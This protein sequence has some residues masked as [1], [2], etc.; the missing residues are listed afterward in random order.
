MYEWTDV[1][2]IVN[3]DGGTVEDNDR[4]THGFCIADGL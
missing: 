1:V 2:L 4:L 3:E